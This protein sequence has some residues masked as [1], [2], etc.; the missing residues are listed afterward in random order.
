VDGVVGRDISK[1]IAVVGR[2][3]NGDTVNDQAGYFIALIGFEGKGL[4]ISINDLDC[5]RFD[6][7]A[8]TF[9]T[10]INDERLL[11]E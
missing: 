2:Q 7:G 1:G 9:G 4:A 11:A 3:G 6:D 8:A 5:A 10:G